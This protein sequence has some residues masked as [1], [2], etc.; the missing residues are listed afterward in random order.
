MPVQKRKCGRRLDLSRPFAADDFVAIRA[1]LAE[2]RR[3]RH[4]SNANPHRP[5]DVDLCSANKSEGRAVDGTRST[6]HP[7]LL[8]MQQTLLKRLKVGVP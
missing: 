2:L 7:E 5:S 4:D 1:R 8:P 6:A 3:D